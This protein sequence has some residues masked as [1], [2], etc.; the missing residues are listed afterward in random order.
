MS[1]RKARCRMKPQWNEQGLLL[2]RLSP[3]NLSL[4]SLSL[5]NRLLSLSQKQTSLSLSKTDF[6]LSL[7]LKKLEP[8]SPSRGTK[9][10]LSHTHLR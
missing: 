10:S 1:E 6:S 7:P 9:P 5:K 3:R 2:A 8:S 4:F